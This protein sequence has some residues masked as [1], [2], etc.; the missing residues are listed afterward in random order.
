MKLSQRNKCLPTPPLTCK[1]CTEGN[2]DT[3]GGRLNTKKKLVFKISYFTFL[4][5][6]GAGLSACS[7]YNVQQQ[8]YQ[9]IPVQQSTDEI[10]SMETEIKPYRDSLELEMNRVI[11]FADTSFIP[12][13]PC[14]NLNNWSADAVLTNQIKNV[15]L[16]APVMALFNFGGLRSTINKG[17]ITIGDIFKVSP[18][19]NM[20]VWARMPI[21]VLPEIEAFLIKTGGEPISGAVLKNGK[22]VVNGITKDTKE[23]I[24][25]T[26][27]YLANGGDKMYFFQKAIEIIH[28]GKLVRECLLIEAKEQGT[29][30]SNPEIRIKLK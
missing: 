28:T 22:L 10:S 18:F 3:G 30:I 23:F 24:V 16:N 4:F 21:E 8:D 13:R 17:E 11:A 20:V 29:L 19:D 25:I 26:S 12:E 5:I 7:S 1:A 27:D 9:L 6:I 2:G 14:G 15:R